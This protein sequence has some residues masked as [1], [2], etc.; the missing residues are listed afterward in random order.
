VV[1]A[2][3]PAGALWAR[4]DGV[5]D[6]TAA[7]PTR[8]RP[9][10]LLMTAYAAEQVL[11]LVPLLV[12]LV[13]F[14]VGGVLAI[15]W[16][17][18][19]LVFV[20]ILLV[21]L[22]ADRQR[23]I[24]SQVLGIDLPPA[25]RPPPAG[26]PLVR[27]WSMVGDPMTWR[28]L[29]WLLWAV[30][31]GWVVSLVVVVLMLAVATLFFWWFGTPH[32]MALRSRVDLFFLSQNATERLRERVDVL[33]RSRADVVDH[34]A[35]ELR[36]LERDLHDGTQARLVAVSMSLGLAEAQF[37]ADP[38]QA[39]RTVNEAKEATSAAIAD[40]RSVVR[41]IHPPVLA[42]RGLDGAVRALA[43]D[44]AVP[45]EVTGELPGRAP[46]PIESAVYFAVAECLANSAK[47]AEHANAWVE[48]SHEPSATTAASG[49]LR[50]VV[51]DD[52]RGGADG[53]RGT[54]MRGVAR[55]LAAFDGTMAV[56]SPVGGPTI[57][58]LE[59]P[60]VL[61]APDGSSSARTTPS[62]ASG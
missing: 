28:D 43:L 12:A 21:R 32:V 36:R 14:L 19:A 44:M 27:L 24:A 17:G 42:D 11:W 10:P 46:L 60:C 57:V 3:L 59:V 38:E 45:V 49:L 16:V 8:R 13:L 5:T 61:T 62:S 40:L 9:G 56:S 55:R 33:T 31:V 41:G 23:R 4:M 50:V 7:A 22:I 30:S 20:A 35:A 39:R 52:G 53:D 1:L 2:P 47:H 48:L 34:S 26:G 37:D 54:G 6:T 18:M 58:T 15:V 25:Y 29:A 51:G